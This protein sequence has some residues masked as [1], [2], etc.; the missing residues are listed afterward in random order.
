MSPKKVTTLVSRTILNRFRRQLSQLMTK[1]VRKWLLGRGDKYVTVP[2][3][4]Q[5]CGQTAAAAAHGAD[6]NGELKDG[7]K[8]QR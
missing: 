6:E 8:A 2:H 7:H 5:C 3:C 4:L 1:G